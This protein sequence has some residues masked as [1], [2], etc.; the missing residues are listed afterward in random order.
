MCT[1]MH[2]QRGENREPILRMGFSISLWK[3]LGSH[4]GTV[5]VLLLRANIIF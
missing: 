3:S 1:H 4:F 5:S 2:T